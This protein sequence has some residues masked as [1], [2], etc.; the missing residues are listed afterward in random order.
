M[1]LTSNNTPGLSEALKR[2]CLFLHVDYPD[3][4]RGA[5]RP[6]QG[7]GHHRLAGRPGG[8]DRPLDP[9]A[10]V[11]EAAVGVETLD[12][13][14]TLLLLGVEQVDATTA[15]GTANIL[16]KYQSDIAKATNELGQDSSLGG[17]PAGAAK[18]WR[19]A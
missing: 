16:L 4:D 9:P 13:G 11:E 2:R 1:F 18:P 3:L 6:H 5:D 8:A 15:T 14:R 12:W 19:N 10:G 7:A 17:E